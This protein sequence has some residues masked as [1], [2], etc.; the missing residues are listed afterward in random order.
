MDY[1]HPILLVVW[2]ATAPVVDHRKGEVEN[3]LNEEGDSQAAGGA[4]R[5]G[6]SQAAGAGAPE[7]GSRAAGGAARG[8]DSRAA[9][10]GAQEDNSQAA[11][12]NGRLI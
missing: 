8:G 3:K 1:S 4:A 10:G 9:G 11:D 6:D 2:V 5:E 12:S 7:G